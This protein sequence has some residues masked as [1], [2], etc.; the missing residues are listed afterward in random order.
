MEQLLR[1]SLA[2][3]FLL[4]G[5]GFSHLGYRE[6]MVLAFICSGLMAAI[7]IYVELRGKR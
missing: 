7:D 3:G 4:L 6:P 2:G 1:L 5:L